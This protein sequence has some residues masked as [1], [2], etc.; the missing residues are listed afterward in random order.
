[1]C[2]VNTDGVLTLFSAN[3]ELNT[4]LCVKYCDGGGDGDDWLSPTLDT[5]FLYPPKSEPCSK[6]SFQHH[7]Q[8]GTEAGLLLYL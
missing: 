1:M 6:G 8:L 7:G 4:R 2:R 3:E 5:M